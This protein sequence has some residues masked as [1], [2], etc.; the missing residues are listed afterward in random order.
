MSRKEPAKKLADGIEII[1]G[2]AF[3]SSGFS[4]HKGMPLIRIR[5]LGSNVAE[6]LF[7]GHFEQIYRV[8]KND[9]L[10]GMDGDFN[11]YK[12]QGDDALLNQ[13]VC[14]IRTDSPELHQDF[15]FWFLI[16]EISR[17]HKLTPQTTV[18]HLSTKDITA[19]PFPRFDVKEQRKIA[20]ILDT[21][22]TTIRETEAIIAK[23]KAVKQGL[24]H[25]MLTRGLDE[26]G[27]LRPPQSEAP[28]LYKDSPLGWIPRQ[29]EQTVLAN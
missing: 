9:L 1:S 21:L 7:D 12:W 17:I 11:I 20:R 10:I 23:L 29:W 15:L 28:H 5:D 14:K 2:F 3:P 13:R 18:R 4:R 27:E 8:Y 6:I 25:D 19:I 26:N 16:P 22:D 24:L